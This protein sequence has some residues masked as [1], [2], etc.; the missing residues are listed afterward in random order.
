MV[1]FICFSDSYVFVLYLDLLLIN[2]LQ[3]LFLKSFSGCFWLAK[4]VSCFIHALLEVFLNGE[5]QLEQLDLGLKPLV[6]Y[7]RRGH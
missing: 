3:Q 2:S 4:F 5:L 1:F 7:G 6:L